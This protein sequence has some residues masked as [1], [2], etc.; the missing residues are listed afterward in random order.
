VTA[1]NELLFIKTAEGVEMENEKRKSMKE[2]KKNYIL[3]VD[4]FE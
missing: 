3:K 2:K 4:D 1:V